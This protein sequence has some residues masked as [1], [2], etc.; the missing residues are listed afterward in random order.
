MYDTGDISALLF[1]SI[2]Q[3]LRHDTA[4]QLSC[5]AHSEPDPVAISDMYVMKRQ[6]SS[7]AAIVAGLIAFCTRHDQGVVGVLCMGWLLQLAVQF[8]KRMDDTSMLRNLETYWPIIDLGQQLDTVNNIEI[9]GYTVLC[10]KAF[11][12]WL[13]MRHEI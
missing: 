6:A 2:F 9:A 3:L 8:C 5:H 10:A 12:V 4:L 7:A 11:G 13:L 1:S